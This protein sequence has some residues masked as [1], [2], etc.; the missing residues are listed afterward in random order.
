MPIIFFVISVILYIVAPTIFS[1]GYCD[2]LHV[3]FIANA[4]YVLYKDKK[5]E[6]IGF[7]LF[8]TISFY[9][10]TYLYPIFVYPIAENYSLFVYSIDSSIITKSTAL[11]N[12]AYSAYVVGYI[13][14]RKK[15]VYA[16]PKPIVSYNSLNSILYVEIILFIVFCLIGGLEFFRSQY[17]H[18]NIEIGGLVG[19]MQVFLRAFTLFL[20]IANYKNNK[21]SLYIALF[22]ICTIFLSTGARGFAM[23]I[24]IVLFYFFVEKYKPSTL[25]I[26]L[27]IGIGILIMATIG[28]YRGNNTVGDDY[29]SDSD[30]GMLEVARDYIINNRNLYSLYSYVQDSSITYGVSSLSHILAVIPFAQSFISYLFNIPP[31]MMRSEMITTTIELGSDSTL[32]LGTHIVGD[33]YLSFGFIGVIVLF[34]A[35]GYII[36]YTRQKKQEGYWWGTIIYFTLLSQAIIMCRGSYFVSLKNIVWILL[37]TYIIRAKGINKSHNNK[38]N[39]YSKL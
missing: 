26:V 2:V 24:L 10:V 25:S 38:A 18:E 3:I 33:V 31:Y 32:G 21:I 28:Q 30:I 16:N 7:N 27:Y 9:G 29:I 19:V 14:H 37:F 13:R 39:S 23:S 22:F 20:C 5:N 8:F 34:Y 35:L 15:T 17:T 1:S 11:A 36:Q 4:F 12:I 6:I